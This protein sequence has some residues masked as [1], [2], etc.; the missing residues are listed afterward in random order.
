[1]TQE[2]RLPATDS[3]A[4]GSSASCT[5]LDD[6]QAV[7]E[8][9]RVHVRLH[10][11]EPASLPPYLGSTLR[12]GLASAMRRTAC[13]APGERECR[14]CPLAE[15]CLYARVFE[16]QVP[17]GSSWLRGI[18]EAPRPYV[19]EPLQGSTPEGERLR[20]GRGAALSFDLLLV[21]QAAEALPFLIGA[22]RGM[23]VA[24][25]GT[26]RHRFSLTAVDIEE[27][28][29]SG[30]YLPL[31]NGASERFVGRPQTT[32]LAFY[33]PTAPPG[34]VCRLELVL[35]TPLRLV[36][37]GAL[38]RE[39]VDF[40]L[41]A[42]T[43]LRRASSLATFHGRGHPEL[44]FAGLA[45]QARHVRTVRSA[46]RWVE[47]VRYSNRQQGE[48]PLG[49]LVGE[50]VFEGEISTFVPLL[51]LGEQIHAGKGTV[52]GLGRYVLHGP[53]SSQG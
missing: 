18:D 28:L 37:Q 30:E 36:A 51:R 20:L 8:L 29:G 42:T 2:Q 17:P 41:L 9:L 14:R 27:P 25:L 10:S 53:Q 45:E 3:P 13:A 31:F 12:G 33:P 11:E 22:L 5:G 7:L 4:T 46:L 34:D 21:G 15:R 39:R 47:N 40:G 32:H 52:F 44:D 50:L 43:I 26:R 1:M 23:A 49:G 6:G 35:L 24:G 19:V 16:P 38:Q 48:V